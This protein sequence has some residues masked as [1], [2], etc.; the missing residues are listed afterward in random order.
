MKAFCKSL[1]LEPDDLHIWVGR[2]RYI[3][4]FSPLWYVVNLLRVAA[5]AFS[6]WAYAVI[7]ILVFG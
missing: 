7:M 3:R 1:G 2:R 5:L 6:F 4:A